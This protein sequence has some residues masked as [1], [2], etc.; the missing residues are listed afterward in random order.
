MSDLPDP[1]E[2][3]NTIPAAAQSNKPASV[4]GAL[5]AGAF[6]AG[7]IA[8]IAAI[9]GFNLPFI[10]PGFAAIMLPMMAG[11]VA[12][13]TS[14]FMRLGYVTNT[15]RRLAGMVE[16]AAG[17][18]SAAAIYQ[19]YPIALVNLGLPPMADTV[20]KLFFGGIAIIHT[21][22]FFKHL[23]GLIRGERT[24]R[25]GRGLKRLERLDRIEKRRKQEQDSFFED[26]P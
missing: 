11:P 6:N 2:S 17:A 13:M 21:I 19:F 23:V 24:D 3:G 9:P 5:F 18:W 15:T 4:P 12:S 26:E 1:D 16:S 14:A 10:L 8:L 22:G 20:A 7:M 25:P